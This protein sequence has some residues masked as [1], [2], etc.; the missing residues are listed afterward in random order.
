MSLTSETV[1]TIKLDNFAN[2]QPCINRSHEVVLNKLINIVTHF[3]E[4]EELKNICIVA[5][6][7]RKFLFIDMIN[8][9]TVYTYDPIHDHDKYYSTRITQY[10]NFLQ[11]YHKFI[12]IRYFT[13]QNKL[14]FCVMTE[15]HFR[16]ETV[17]PQH[18][19]LFDL[20][21]STKNRVTFDIMDLTDHLIIV[22]KS[23]HHY[24]EN[25][26]KILN[27]N[28]TSHDI[29]REYTIESVY[30]KEIVVLK[31]QSELCYYYSMKYKAVIGSGYFKEWDKNIAVE[32]DMTDKMLVMKQFV[33]NSPIMNIE[34]PTDI[35]SQDDAIT[36]TV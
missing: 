14:I 1:H 33:E 23:N 32:F 25:A 2:I 3:P 18:V 19:I 17:Y 16:M 29:L 28:F 6:N 26:I 15:F 11:D 9:K 10:N 27:K 31:I 34:E 4:L 13:W 20:V 7:S 8:K 30:N 24:T 35:E 5:E 21:A 22:I 12:D 36:E